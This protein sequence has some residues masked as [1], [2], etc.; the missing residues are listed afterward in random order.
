MEE[1]ICLRL[2]GPGFASNQAAS[3]VLSHL[4]FENTQAEALLV[5]TH[6]SGGP[7]SVAG[8]VHAAE[9]CLG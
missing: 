8:Q 6:M 1:N 3:L 2:A 9:M 4:G 5:S 7:G